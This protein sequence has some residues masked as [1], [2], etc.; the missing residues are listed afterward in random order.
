MIPNF[1]ICLKVVLE[2]NIYLVRNGF[3]LDPVEYCDGA[4]HL[5]LLTQIQLVVSTVLCE[6]FPHRQILFF[7]PFDVNNLLMKGFR[8]EVF[9]FPFFYLALI[10]LVL[11]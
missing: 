1:V 6:G 5:D 3:I 8:F 9:K 4:G 11:V 2:F 7:I 10:Q